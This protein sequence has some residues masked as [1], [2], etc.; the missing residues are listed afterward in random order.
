MRLRFYAERNVI[1]ETVGRRLLH[2]CVVKRRTQRET[3]YAADEMASGCVRYSTGHGVQRTERGPH[4][5][6]NATA[7][8]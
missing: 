7:T 1:T 5:P 8:V 4:A 3:I 6:Q 2:Q